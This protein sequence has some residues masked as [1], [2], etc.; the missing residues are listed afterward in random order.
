MKNSIPLTLLCVTLILSACT[1]NAT[2]TA[3]PTLVLE[4]TNANPNAAQPPASSGETVSASGVI[5]PARDAQL[6]FA[7]AANVSQVNVAEGD[8]VQ[9]GQV[10]AE[11]DNTSIQVE[12][13]QAERLLREL[14]SPAAIAAA[15]QAIVT[16]Q[17][18]YEDAQKKVDS[19]NYRKNNQSDIEYYK[20]QLVLAQKNLD[21]AREA[22]NKTR[23]L[24]AA[25]PVRAAATTNLYNAQKAYNTALWNLEWF[26]NTPEGDE[27]NLAK[28]NL[29]AAAAAL[30]EA[31]WYASELK[32]ESVPAD[33]TGAQLA[34]L[35]QARDNLKA[36][37]D[38]L[39]HTRLIA[40]FSGT[41]ITVNLAA[42]EYVVPGQAVISLSDVTN[43]Q[44]E[45][46]DLSERDVAHVSVGQKAS[47]YIEALN[48]EVNGHVTAISPVANTLGG[49]VVYKTTIVLDELPEG[50][51]AGMTVTV[52]YLP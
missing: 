21:R 6:A 52:Q 7:L 47:I 44:A 35:Q 27:V 19:I 16:A 45:T 18:A 29:D 9:E 13:E 49:D 25:D 11:L 37:Q 24:S 38:R 3:I 42:G 51:R 31:Q 26:T 50:V 33:A 22:Y 2:P 46:T 1:A 39:E 34:K 41:V 40:P 43:L 23:K 36:A 8:Q 10:L 4:D 14:T 32:G 48:V 12:V 5:V 28:A 17:K 15:E 20:A 30:Q